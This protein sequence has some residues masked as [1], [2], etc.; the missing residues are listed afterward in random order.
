MKNGLAG[1]LEIVNLLHS[2]G[3]RFPGQLLVTA[4]GLHE[5]PDGNS[6][7]ILDL[8]KRGIAGDAAI[9]FET[10]H[11]AR[12]KAVVCGK[13]QS[14]WNVRISRQGGV[15]HEL[16]RPADADDLLEAIHLVLKALQ[17]ES[18][19][20]QKSKAYPLLGP[21]TLF[22]GQVHY[23]DFY[24]RCSNDCRLQ[25]TRRWTPGYRFADVARDFTA[26]LSGMHLPE[27]VSVECEW[28]FVGEAYEIDPC[29]PIV[30]HLQAAT[31]EIMGTEAPLAGISAIVDANRLV[32]FG[33]VPT[34]VCGLDCEHA[35]ADYE[36]VRLSELEL[37]CRV[38]LQTSL[39][40]LEDSN[41]AEKDDH[42]RHRLAR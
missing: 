27:T 41:K 34:V 14:I 8:I 32:P 23:G 21:E 37:G 15:S 5:A 25:G 13:G 39:N 11:S 12:G 42:A 40:F 3:C 29:E 26:L 35:H 28:I 33:S 10:V 6:A 36:F 24:N 2:D 20:L 16:N 22:V 4:Y 38:A 30:G 18:R 1:I 9:V 19:R 17:D 31:R 7:T